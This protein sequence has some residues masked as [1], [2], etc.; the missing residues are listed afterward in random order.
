MK[1]RR[2]CR[3]HSRHRFDR[4][5]G[6]VSLCRDET[7]PIKALSTQQIDDLKSRPRM[8]LASPLN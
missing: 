7:R 3:R 6:A 4:R 1:V 5:A 8:G 2:R